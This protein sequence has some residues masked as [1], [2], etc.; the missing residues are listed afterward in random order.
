MCQCVSLKGS[1]E[2]RS[3]KMDGFHAF[4]LTFGYGSKFDEERWKFDLC[5][6]CLVEFIELFKHSPEKSNY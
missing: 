3:Y 5:E 6:N 2:E 1:E 4:N